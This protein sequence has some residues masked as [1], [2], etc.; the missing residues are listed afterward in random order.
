M[1]KGGGKRTDMNSKNVLV[2]PTATMYA[3]EKMNLKDGGGGGGI[4]MHNIYRW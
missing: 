4:E 1:K 2:P 3:G